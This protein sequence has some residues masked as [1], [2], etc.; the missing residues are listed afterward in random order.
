MKL[1]KHV[2]LAATLLSSVALAAAPLAATSQA[3]TSALTTAP[4]TQSE[5]LPNPTAVYVKQASAPVYSDAQ[6]TKKT[7]RTL[8]FGSGW[9]AFTKITTASGD[10]SYNVG[11]NQ[12]V[13][14]ADVTTDP[15]SVST[16]QKQNGVVYVANKAGADTYSWKTG[17]VNGHLAYG[18]GWRYGTVTTNG[19]TRV[20]G[21]FVSSDQILQVEDVTGAKPGSTSTTTDPSKLGRGVFT[22]RYAAHPSWS[23][24]KYTLSN[25]TLKYAGSLPA[26]SRWLAYGTMQIGG[27]YY[28]DLGG[29]FVP[30]T[31]G[32]F[33][34]AK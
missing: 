6:L 11:G 21:Y 26:G 9:R 23:I 14:A 25:G 31:Y 2:L 27:Q 1:S 5:A 12:Y 16:V 10:L 8:S 19:T 3:A 22:V 18:T 24:A 30:V 4:K 28:F 17:K 33:A 20:T 13:A 34:P 15:N 32:T 29:Q 7:G